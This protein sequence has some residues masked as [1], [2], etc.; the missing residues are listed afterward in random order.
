LDEDGTRTNKSKSGFKAHSRKA[1][2][3]TGLEVNSIPA[4]TGLAFGERALCP[5]G[6]EGLS[7]FCW[8]MLQ[9]VAKFWEKN[10]GRA[11]N[12]KMPSIMRIP[13]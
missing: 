4:S 3:G 10:R 1:L 11:K 12:M 13:R 7:P 2:S 8:N 5:Q 9:T 6:P